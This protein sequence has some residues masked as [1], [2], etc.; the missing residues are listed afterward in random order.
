MR[1]ID[2]LRYN[3]TLDNGEELTLSMAFTTDTGK[4]EVDREV[5]SL[6]CQYMYDSMQMAIMEHRYRFLPKVK[7]EFGSG[8]VVIKDPLGDN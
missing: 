5:F 8:Q 7:A 4:S 2:T 3:H 1:H 6:R